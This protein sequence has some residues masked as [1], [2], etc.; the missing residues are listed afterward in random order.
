MIKYN[1]FPLREWH[2]EHMKKTIIKF[3]TGLSNNPSRWEIRQN[4]KYNNI[5]YIQ[6]V[7]DHDLKHGV[8]NN[9]MQVFLQQ[10]DTDSSFM[11]LRQKEGFRERFSEIEN[12][13]TKNR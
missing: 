11:D 10:I 8:T 6:R 12:F 5:F 4:K 13:I 9:E 7:L 2:I 1:N 3:I